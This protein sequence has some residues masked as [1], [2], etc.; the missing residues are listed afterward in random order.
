MNEPKKNDLAKLTEEI[1]CEGEESLNQVEIPRD[2]EH[3][4]RMAECREILREVMDF[5]IRQDQVLQLIFLLA[6][7]LENREAMLAISN[8]AK[9]YKENLFNF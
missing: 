7:E 2:F 9:D 3:T 8:I 1:C 5:G 6:L 4:K